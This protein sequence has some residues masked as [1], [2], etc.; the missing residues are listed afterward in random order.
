VPVASRQISS[1]GRDQ[2]DVGLTNPLCDIEDGEQRSS[3]PLRP[4]ALD[5]SGPGWNRSF[6]NKTPSRRRGHPGTR[7]SDLAGTSHRRATSSSVTGTA[8]RRQSTRGHHLPGRSHSASTRSLANL[9]SARRPDRRSAALELARSIIVRAVRLRTARGLRRRKRFVGLVMERPARPVPLRAARRILIGSRGLNQPA[10][11][12][13][14]SA[15]NTLL[16]GRAGSRPGHGGSGR[17]TLEMKVE[18]RSPGHPCCRLA[19]R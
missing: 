12:R 2:G 4:N 1:A 6:T 9:I 3:L 14:P 19:G 13:R 11:G 5:T 16:G 7:E 15:R 18:D 17:R 10:L 8:K